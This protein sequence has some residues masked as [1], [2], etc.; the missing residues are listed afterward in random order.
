MPAS[1][2]ARPSHED[3]VEMIVADAGGDTRLALSNALAVNRRL[4]AELR[5]L[6]GRRAYDRLRNA[7]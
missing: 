6:A 7:A 5:E 3:I 1:A 4:M 2:Q